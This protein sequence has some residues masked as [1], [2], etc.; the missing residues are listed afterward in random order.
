MLGTRSLLAGRNRPTCMVCNLS[1]GR[2]HE[3]PETLGRRTA[4]LVRIGHNSTTNNNLNWAESYNSSNHAHSAA[5]RRKHLPNR[6]NSSLL[7][8]SLAA[9]LCGA[10]SRT[11]NRRSSGQQVCAIA[12]RIKR[13]E[14]V[15]GV[16]VRGIG[17]F[18]SSVRYRIICSQLMGGGVPFSWHEVC[19]AV[20]D[21]VRSERGCSSPVRVLHHSQHH[22][23]FLVAAT[24][25][26]RAHFDMRI[27][28]RG[29]LLRD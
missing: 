3:R 10:P 5:A 8:S 20:D 7:C 6:W 2:D 17:T 27:R 29:V 19:S 15:Q 25:S 13:S 4:S 23:S 12:G 18:C 11:G 24:R 21:H 9:D 22:S 26:S 16:P 1:L 28:Q 14:G